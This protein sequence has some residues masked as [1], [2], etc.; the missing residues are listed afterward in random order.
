MQS[1]REA[2]RPQP[3]DLG[4]APDFPEPQCPSCGVGAKCERAAPCP[5]PPRSL[6]SIC[7]PCRDCESICFISRP[8]RIVDGHLNMPVCKGMMEAVL[9]HVM[10]RPGVPESCL[11]QHYQGVLQ[12]IVVLELLQVRRGAGLPLPGPGLGSQRAGVVGV[13]D[14]SQGHGRCI[15]EPPTRGSRRRGWPGSL[16]TEPG[17][18][19]EPSAPGAS[20]RCVL[21]LRSQPCATGLPHCS[22]RQLC[23]GEVPGLLSALLLTLCSLALLAASPASQRSLLSLLQ[24]GLTL[25]PALGRHPQRPSPAPRFCSGLNARVPGGSSLALCLGQRSRAHRPWAG[26]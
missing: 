10:A 1:R 21:H 13:L 26:W 7:P 25:G 19:E 14:E 9:Y 5:L 12:P 4:R 24:P 2:V 22:R 16:L 11:L 17:S 18:S 23:R 6:M 15:Q 8:W 20:P 3:C